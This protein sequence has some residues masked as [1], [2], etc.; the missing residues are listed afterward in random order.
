MANEPSAR[1][2]GARF[3]ASPAPELVAFSRSESS[4]FRLVP[5]DLAS[6]MAHARELVR[7]GILTE[8]EAEEA[9]AALRQIGEDYR[10]GRIVP[11]P[12]DEDIHTFLERVLGERT[13]VLGGKLRAG[14]SRNDQAANDLKLYLRDVARSIG[15]DMLAL[16]SALLEQAS[17]HVE[18]VTAGFTHLQ[19]AQPVSFAH[20]LLAHAQT[21][22]RDFDRL[23]DWDRRAARSP[24]GAAALAG[25]AIALQAELS[26]A[27]LGYDAP[28]ENSIDAVGSRDHVAEFLFVT[29]M[30]GVHLS[31]LAEEL[32]LW[33]SR[34]FRWIEMDDA[35]ATGSSIMP[36]KKNCDIAELTR[37][38][39][40]RLIGS[41]STMLVALKGL[42]FAYNRDLAED[43]HAAFDTVDALKLM[44]PAMAGLVRTMRVN[45]ERMAQQSLEGFTLATEVADWLARSGVPFSEA[46]EI[47]G[48]LVRYCEDRSLGLEDLTEA[49]LAAVDPRLLPPIMDCLS[50]RAAI[51]ARSGY[52]GTAPQR[53]SEQIAR[54]AS[55]LNDQRQWL[56]DYSGPSFEEVAKW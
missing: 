1:L 42:P 29:A 33:S 15:S 12:A 3:R 19:P 10:D 51:A 39:S 55:L 22:A 32:F 28:C 41:L 44:V 24:L 21:F 18:T 14:R 52:G 23:Q 47:T 53:V 36:Q 31:R 6:S 9:C 25:S 49:D 50:A 40:A 16:Q 54:L 37:G 43:K 35:Y 30:F 48:A 8:A 34:Q 17:R 38:R 26:A 7:A 20:Q 46:H 5:Y 45:T 27:E 2:W 56:H 13:G 4:Y 11:S